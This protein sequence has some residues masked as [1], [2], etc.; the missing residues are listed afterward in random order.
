MSG[1]LLLAGDENEDE[2]FRPSAAF[3]KALDKEQEYDDS[4]AMAMGERL[5]DQDARPAGTTEVCSPMAS[6]LTYSSGHFSASASSCFFLA[7][8]LMR[9]YVAGV[10]GERVRAEEQTA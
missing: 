6:T 5:G 2:V 4:D 8:L 1:G 10:G 9:R 3:C 7:I